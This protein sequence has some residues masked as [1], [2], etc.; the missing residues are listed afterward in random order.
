M[1][2]VSKPFVTVHALDAGF[3]TLPVS[4]FI[5]PLDDPTVRKTVPSLSFLIQRQDPT[6][7]ETTRI[8]FD[9][10]IRKNLDDY[11]E[12]IRKHLQTRQPASGEPDT[13][14]SLAKGNL[15]PDDIHLIVFSHLH[16]DHIGTPWDYPRSTYV[17][18][19][20]AASLIDGSS[21]TAPGSHNH[22]ESGIIDME[23]LIELPNTQMKSKAGG[24]LSR[25]AP[26][27]VGSASRTSEASS[28]WFPSSKEWK[29]LGPLSNTFD[30]FDDGSVL[31]VDAPGHLDGHINLLCRVADGSYVYLAGDSC[32]DL[33][34][35]T[36]EKEIATWEDAAYPGKICCIHKDPELAKRTL[37]VIRELQMGKTELGAVEVVFAHDAEWEKDAKRRGRFF[38]GSV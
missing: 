10:G 18:G 29:A 16:W 23:R 26:P 34:L 15:T 17:I 9:L 11:A 3:L 35:L 22:F 19:P 38:P 24:A 27:H 21:A 20:G 13:V 25:G 36:G 37:G 1:G 14:A 30:I 28:A 33:R 32:H 6:S 7:G 2:S 31:L 8:V 12:P 5:A 4:F